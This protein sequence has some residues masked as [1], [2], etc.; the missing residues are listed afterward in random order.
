MMPVNTSNTDLIR[1]K[2]LSWLAFN[3]RVLQEANNPDVPL[4]DRFRFLGIYSS[5]LDEFFRVRVA[6]LK[7]L[8]ELDSSKAMELLGKDPNQT[9][10]TL[11]EIV[12]TQRVKYE[13]IQKTLIDELEKQGICFVNE[14]EL[15]ER[16]S[17]FALKYFNQRVRP[18][19]MPVMIDQVKQ[20]PD[21]EDDKIYLAILLSKKTGSHQRYALIEIPCESISR[22]LIIPRIGVRKYI[23]FL[24]DVIRLGLPDLF[25]VFKYEKIDAFTIK[26]T[27][28]AELDIGDDLGESYVKKI[29]RGLKKREAGDPVRFVYDASMP[30]H[31][32]KYLTRHIG[33]RQGDSII[34]GGRYHNLK[35][36]INLPNLGAENLSYSPLQPFI[37]PAVRRRKSIFT[38]IRERDIMMYFP[39]HSFISFIDLLREASIDPKV[40]SIKI[41]LY[42]LAQ[43]SSVINALINAVRNGKQVTAV[44][45]LQARFSEQSNIDY[46]NL[47]R[48][49]GVR[50]VYGVPGLKVHA[51]LCLI[52]RREKGK[53][54]D[55]ACVGTGNF[56]E[57]TARVFCDL[58]LLT[59]KREIADEVSRIFHF[60]KRNY[61]IGT[62]QYLLPAPFT[63]RD[64][65]TQLIRNEIRAAREGLPAYIH[66][67]L[68]N[69]TDPEIINELFEASRAGVQ[70]RLNVRGMFAIIMDPEDP[71]TKNIEAISIVDRFLEH[72]RILF[73][74]NMGKELVYF[75]SADMMTRNLDRRVEVTCPV[76][77]P[78]I[79]EELRSLFDIQW[80]DNSKARI[81]DAGL[82][83]RVKPQNDDSPY[84]SQ[85]EFYKF[86]KEKLENRHLVK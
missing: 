22:F 65:I 84:R 25:Q 43:N 4:I 49:E 78:L 56:N 34:P 38:S 46:S 61:E 14:H 44:M 69:L 45:E 8:S 64:T 73:F 68:N 15:T 30:G 63:F 36:F 16:Q 60:I 58:L 24:D 23:M 48:E 39:Y 1:A 35:D 2:E 37:H 27:K 32:L 7:R 62:Y 42:R 55:Y 18:G 3:E 81:L 70:I 13:K 82:T 10:A 41:T 59:A 74:Y 77:D 83:N 79:K 40:R 9:L 33:L 67:K 5:N 54:I 17:A 86:L 57:E 66:F 50:V 85:Y 11:N 71:R 47:L 6:T 31:F 21:L 20:F 53:D 52:T 75:S 80:R 12:L 76:F 19:L 51:K 26:L 72:A 29:S 28:D